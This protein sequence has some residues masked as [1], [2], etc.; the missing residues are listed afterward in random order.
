MGKKKPPSGLPRDHTSVKGEVV[1][2]ATG[3][4]TYAGKS[5]VRY[6][7]LKHGVFSSK[8]LVSDEDREVFDTLQEELREQL[9]PDT[10]ILQLAFQRVVTAFWRY[11]QAIAMES[12]RLKPQADS[13]ASAKASEPARDEIFALYRGGRQDLNQATRLLLDIRDE[14]KEKGG[15]HLEKM[16]E[17]ISKV[18]GASFFEALVDWTPKNIAAVL[19]GEALAAHAKKTQMELNPKEVTLPLLADRA[20]WDMS[21]KLI[22]QELQHINDLRVLLENPSVSAQQEAGLDTFNRYITSAAREFE[23]AVAWYFHLQE[24]AT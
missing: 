14:L 4:R 8:L 13:D 3:P 1:S 9:K 16:K 23:R 19:A 6:N 22:D 17:S 5:R 18:F 12:A 21:M 11:R 15:L 24:Q 7:A 20:R 2:R 10:A